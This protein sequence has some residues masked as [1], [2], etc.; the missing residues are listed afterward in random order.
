MQFQDRAIIISAT[1]YG[2]SSLIVKLLTE[3][4]GLYSGLVRSVR[5]NN[6][7]CQVG[8]IVSA[9]WKARLEEHLGFFTIELEKSVASDIFTDSLKLSALISAC[10]I[11][12]STLPEREPHKEFFDVFY[13]L[14]ISM[15]SDEAIWLEKYVL[16]ELELLKYTGFGLDISSCA[17]TGAHDDLTYVSPKSARAVCETSGRPYHDKLLPLPSFL[18]QLSDKTQ[19]D[20]AE[21]IDG[22]KLTGYFLNRYIFAQN[23]KKTPESRARF[24][25]N[26]LKRA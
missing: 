18:Q 22:M 10:E 25:K 3:N 19:A 23:N 20:I 24:V 15:R 11:I 9:N 4:N 26:I 14:L 16:F 17:D 8:N 5:K 13:E 2:E 6:S 1:K 12:K 7:I 21:I